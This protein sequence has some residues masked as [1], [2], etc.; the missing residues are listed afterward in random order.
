MLEN[1]TFAIFKMSNHFFNT[2]TKCALFLACSGSVISRSLC[3]ISETRPLTE[4]EKT[5][6]IISR[7]VG[8]MSVFYLIG[9]WIYIG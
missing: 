5:V 1:E 6:A 8:T 3:D 9:R 4:R 2:S 7:N